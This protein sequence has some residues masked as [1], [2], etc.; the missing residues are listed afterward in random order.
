MVE[1]KGYTLEEIS[2]AFDGSTVNL[3]SSSAYAPTT[4]Y[5][6]EHP[7]PDHSS[8]KGRDLEEAK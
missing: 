7:S 1:T 4:L 2:G 8:H 5:E 3:V 6:Q